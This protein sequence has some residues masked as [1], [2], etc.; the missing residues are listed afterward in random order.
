[1]YFMNVF[2]PLNE[3][4]PEKKCMFLGTSLID[5]IV[6]V[7]PKRVFVGDD[8]IHQLT[9]KADTIMYG[10]KMTMEGRINVFL[11]NING[12]LI[13]AHTRA[14]SGNIARSL[15]NHGCNVK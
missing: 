14:I 8:D 10:E 7:N 5:S 9:E 15:R 11:F 6:P 4:E 12:N 13:K 3:I 2:N 1:M